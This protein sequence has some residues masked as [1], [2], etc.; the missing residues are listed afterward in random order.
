MMKIL[1]VAVASLYTANAISLYV[2]TCRGSNPEYYV[3]MGT[4][5]T[6]LLFIYFVLLGSIKLRELNSLKNIKNN[7]DSHAN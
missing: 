4:S 1:S 5:L 7:G 6:I 3:W 2:Y